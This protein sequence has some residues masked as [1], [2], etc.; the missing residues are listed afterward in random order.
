V[1]HR[2]SMGIDGLDKAYKSRSAAAIHANYHWGAYHFIRHNGSGEQQATWFIKTLL[3]SPNHPKAVLLVI[4]AKYLHG[5]NS[6]HPTLPQIVDCVK[7]VHELTGIYPGIYTGQDFLREQLHKEH[8]DT[9]TQDVFDNTWLWVA[10]YSASRKALAFPEV[11]H[12]P[13]NMWK[14]LASV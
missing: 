11:S 7:R 6:P 10:R 8:Y 4:D 14:L 2:S 13:W 9:A 1:I 3:N 5:T 12:P